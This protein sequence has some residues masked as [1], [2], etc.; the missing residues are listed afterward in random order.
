MLKGILQCASF[1]IRTLTFF[2]HLVLK[3]DLVLLYMV[4]LLY[5]CSSEQ[6]HIHNGKRSQEGTLGDLLPYGKVKYNEILHL[7]PYVPEEQN[8]V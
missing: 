8:H 4:I 1:K 2:Y 3:L 6:K 5:T 7:F